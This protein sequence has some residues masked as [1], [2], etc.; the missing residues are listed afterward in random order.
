MLILLLFLSINNLIG[1]F[2]Y[3]NLLD[4]F[5]NYVKD[6]HKK[7]ILEAAMLDHT[8]NISHIMNTN[9]VDFQIN[10]GL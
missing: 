1:K 3:P 8:S 5:N 10:K 9:G 7:I 6:E 4:E 2:G